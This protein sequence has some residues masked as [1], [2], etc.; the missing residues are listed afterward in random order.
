[1]LHPCPPF[2]SGP[3]SRGSGSGAGNPTISLQQPCPP[4]PPRRL[5]PVSLCPAQ[6]RTPPR[7]PGGAQNPARPTWAPP[8]AQVAQVRPRAGRRSGRGAAGP[9]GIRCSA[10]RR[11]SARLWPQLRW[12]SPAEFRPGSPRPC[13]GEAGALAFIPGCLELE[14]GENSARVCARVRKLRKALGNRGCLRTGAGP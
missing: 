7:P 3:C 10:R 11:P 12:R 8:P 4:P 6:V 2:N 9:L 14:R 13:A 1:M 5:W